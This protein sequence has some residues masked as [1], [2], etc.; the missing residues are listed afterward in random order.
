MNPE[1]VEV[2]NDLWLFSWMITLW[3]EKHF[4]EVASRNLAGKS[5][6]ESA[7]ESVVSR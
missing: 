5:A 1:Q 6:S 4:K 2:G 3:L 7:S